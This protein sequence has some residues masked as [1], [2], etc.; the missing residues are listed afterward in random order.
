MYLNC[1]I[2]FYT[3]WFVHNVDSFHKNLV[4][5]DVTPKLLLL[6]LFYSAK[7]SK[8]CMTNVHKRY[9]NQART[10]GTEKVNLI[11]NYGS[12][13]PVPILV[14]ATYTAYYNKDG[15]MMKTLLNNTYLLYIR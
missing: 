12:M 1:I 14:V 15:G 4:Y 7:K 6:L 11:Y 5:L 13:P 2:L 9:C 3:F 8:H 10:P